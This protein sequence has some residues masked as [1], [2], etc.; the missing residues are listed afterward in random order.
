MYMCTYIYIAYA[1]CMPVHVPYA[2]GAYAHPVRIPA[3]GGGVGAVV[4]LGEGKDV[5][6]AV[7]GV[8][9]VGAAVAVAASQID[10][11]TVGTTR[12]LP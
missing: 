11:P 2:T 6:V 8:A 3:A 12:I 10:L 4:R 1:G 7:V 5:G 9:V